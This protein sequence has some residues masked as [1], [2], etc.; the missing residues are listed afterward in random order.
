MINIATIALCAVICGVDDFVVL[1]RFGNTKRDWLPR[2]LDL[3]EGVPSHDRF[4]AILAAIRPEEFE[5]CLLGWNQALHEITVGQIIAIDGKTLR[6]SYDNCPR[7][8][9]RQPDFSRWRSAPR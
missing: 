9:C 7:Q 2:F 8:N 1:E 3:D 5:A 6:R 4:K